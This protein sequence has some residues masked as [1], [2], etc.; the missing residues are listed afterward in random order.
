MCASPQL[1]QEHLGTSFELDLKA[2]IIIVDSSSYLGYGHLHIFV[3]TC[4][5]CSTVPLQYALLM[6][7]GLKR[8]VS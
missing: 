2:L 5:L 8:K 6:L 4:S 7:T 3:H 1:Q